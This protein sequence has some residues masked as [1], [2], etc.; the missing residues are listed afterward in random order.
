MP[1]GTKSAE[2]VD[3]IRGCRRPTELAARDIKLLVVACN[4]ASAVALDDPPG[5][6]RPPDRR[7]GGSRRASGGAGVTRAGRSRSHRHRLDDLEWCVRARAGDPP[8]RSSRST[9]APARCSCPLAEEGW[10]DTRGRGARCARTTWR[11]S[12]S[13]GSTRSS[14]AAR[15][16]RSSSPSSSEPSATRPTLV[17]S[18]EETGKDVAE[19]LRSQRRPR[20]PASPSRPIRFL[21][22]DDHEPFVRPSAHAC[23]SRADPRQVERVDLDLRIGLSSPA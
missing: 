16:T 17:D 15:T 6:P 19:R 2:T 5:R 21:V 9:G 18:A 4:T 13:R 3:P 11:T 8:H 22:T 10:E 12:R 14:S 7:R 20:P 23:L 1:Y